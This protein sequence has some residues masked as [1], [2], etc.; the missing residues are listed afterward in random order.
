MK[1]ASE[2]CGN[3]NAALVR[4]YPWA[5]FTTDVSDKLA[6]DAS[7]DTSNDRLLI[8]SLSITNEDPSDLNNLETYK[9]DIYD[10]RDYMTGEND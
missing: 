5:P 2:T 9:N 8:Y 1:L 6:A 7:Y 3:L 10:D 4:A